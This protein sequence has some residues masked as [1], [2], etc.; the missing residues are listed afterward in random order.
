MHLD[1]HAI[2][3]RFAYLSVCASGDYVL[4]TLAPVD[5]ASREALQVVYERREQQLCHSL[6]AP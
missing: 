6:T 5:N 2:E 3:A 4:C 1:G